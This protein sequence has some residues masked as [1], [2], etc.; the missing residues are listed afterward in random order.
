MI[1]I[2]RVLVW[3]SRMKKHTSHTARTSL[4]FRNRYN[5][6]IVSRDMTCFFVANSS[7]MIKRVVHIDYTDQKNL[8]LHNIRQVRPRLFQQ[9]CPTMRFAPP[10]T[11]PSPNSTCY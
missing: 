6:N 11:T 9:L 10:S 7:Q 5:S 1:E 8:H 4:V 3:L 2:M